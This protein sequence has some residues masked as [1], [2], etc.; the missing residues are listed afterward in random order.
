M[1][2]TCKRRGP[3]QR[4]WLAPALAGAGALV[5]P[6]LSRRERRDQEVEREQPPVPC[7]EPGLRLCAL[8]WGRAQAVG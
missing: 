1:R 6:A 7:G 3:L 2:E 5:Q 8:C 4:S